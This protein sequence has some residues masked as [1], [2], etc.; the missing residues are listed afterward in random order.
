VETP[1]QE[2]IELDTMYRDPFALFFVIIFRVIATDTSKDRGV[3][4]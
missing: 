3:S 2:R 1:A 4:R